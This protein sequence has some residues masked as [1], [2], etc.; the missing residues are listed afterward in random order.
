KTTTDEQ[1]QASFEFIVPEN[2]AGR[3]QDGG[4]RIGLQATI[5]DSAGQKETRHTTSVVSSE[6]LR[7][8]AIPEGGTLL[9]SIANRGR[10]F[11]GYPDGQP[12]AKAKILVSGQEEELVTNEY[13][14]AVFEFTPKVQE[15][16]WTIKA[17][18]AKGRVGRKTAVYQCGQANQD[19]VLRTDQAVYTGG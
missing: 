17:T 10:R 12:A 13:G 8:E 19:F 4:A 1:G 14:V 3:E 5:T 7:V 9:S 11:A 2:L 18:D 6:L 16:T 15:G